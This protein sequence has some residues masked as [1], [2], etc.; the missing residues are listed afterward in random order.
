MM[1]SV[2]ILF[3]VLPAYADIYWE[4]LVE[5]K[6]TPK[7][8]SANLPQ[9]LMGQFNKSDTVKYWLSEQGMRTESSDG[10]MILDY[11]AMTFY[12]LY[13]NSKTY[14]KT[15]MSAMTEKGKV[16]SGEMKITATE[17][18]RNISGYP[19]RKYRVT[20][21]NGEGEYWLSKE[22]TVY[23]Q[24]KKLKERIKSAVGKIP[25]AERMKIPG[26]TEEMDG[27]PVMTRMEVMGITTTSTVKQAEEKKTDAS[28]YRVPD[29]YN[30][31][32]IKNIFN[33]KQKQG[34]E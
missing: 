29:D 27:F 15:D 1:F 26:L 20:L 16:Q 28:L 30:L 17:E 12:N 24:Y 21:T 3:A 13:P 23:E 9:I 34:K 10:I 8:M 25:A 4:S 14:M 6:G 2:L 7:G 11:R 31:V 18:S 19:C 32:D 5:S 33:L 22:V